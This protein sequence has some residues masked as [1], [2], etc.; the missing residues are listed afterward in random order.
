MSGR[1][2][3]GFELIV[4]RIE[5]G[6]LLRRRSGKQQAS[7]STAILVR[8]VEEGQAFRPNRLI[9]NVRGVIEM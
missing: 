4:S 8:P 3:P 6:M 9:K 7:V 2:P 5:K 1:E